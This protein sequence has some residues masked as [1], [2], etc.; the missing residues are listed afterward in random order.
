MI[1][2]AIPFLFLQSSAVDPNV[3]CIHRLYGQ[4]FA[5]LEQHQLLNVQLHLGSH[6]S[7][8]HEIREKVMRLPMPKSG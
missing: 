6:E 5:G 4:D 7:I 8:A 1:H 3:K 2:I